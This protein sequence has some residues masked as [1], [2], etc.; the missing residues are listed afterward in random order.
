MKKILSF[1]IPSYNCEKFLDKCVLSML[2]DE[3]SDKL[4]IIIVNDG[5]M[6]STADI[7]NRYAS[8]YPDVVRAIH[9]ENKGH[10]GALNTGLSAAKG[11]YVKVIDADDWV[12]TDNL[13]LFIEKLENT[14]ADVV[15]TH[16][17]TTDIS[18]GEVKKWKC[19]PEQFEK[20]Y[21]FRAVMRS[22]KSFDRSLTFHG[23]TYNT[24]FY[25]KNASPLAE[26]V[27]YEDHEYATF[28]CCLAKR[29]VPLDIFIY[30]YRIGDVAQSVSDENQLRRLSHFEAVLDAMIKKYSQLRIPAKCKGR[31]FVA[32]KVQVL[33]LSLVSTCL[34]V[35]KDRKQGR[36]LA[37]KV[38]QKVKQQLESAYEFSYKKYRVFLMMNYLHISKKTWDRF[39]SSKLYR[40]LSGSHDFS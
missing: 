38:M 19:Y 39:R 6:D 28:P 16:H 31:E 2:C 40:K 17:Y 12:E 9:Q 15:L 27:F 24:E 10:G 13:P 3:I 11:K 23:I 36:E 1:V 20:A 18:T 33:V 21:D 22:W 29:I 4:E 32:R 25:H 5:S 26:K 34:L 30:N 37:E 35:N 8:Q 14:D 7:A